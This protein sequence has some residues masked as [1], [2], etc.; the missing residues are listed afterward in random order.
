MKLLTVFLAALT[1]T[2][3]QDASH[4]DEVRKAFDVR[5]YAGGF[6]DLGEIMANSLEAVQK[7]GQDMMALRIAGANSMSEEDKNALQYA[8]DFA[9]EIRNN[10]DFQNLA[11]RARSA[12][13]ASRD[14]AD[15]ANKRINELLGEKKN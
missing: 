14:V 10:H 6:A 8:V 11:D 15:K 7:L 12:G 13:R 3:A 5:L 1:T 2:L 9:D 4:E